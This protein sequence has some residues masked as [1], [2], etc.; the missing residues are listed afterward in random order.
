MQAAHSQG[1]RNNSGFDRLDD[2]DTDYASVY[3]ERSVDFGSDELDKDLS[4]SDTLQ[5]ISDLSNQIA[6]LRTSVEC[7]NHTRKNM[8]TGPLPGKNVQLAT[9]SVCSSCGKLGHSK[10]DRN[11]PA[12]GS[13]CHNCDKPGH[14]TSVCH[15]PQKNQSG[16]AP[17]R[18]NRTFKTKTNKT[19]RTLFVGPF[20]PGVGDGKKSVD[21][22]STPNSVPD[23][24]R[25]D[26]SVKEAGRSFDPIRLVKKDS[27]SA[28]SEI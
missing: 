25:Q 17:P 15:A 23:Q 5:E 28:T 26:C 9:H 2:S 14:W 24:F 12:R 22:E 8:Y 13:T 10:T 11:C 16:R 7:R 1:R 3:G 20:I 6:K 18:P 21:S 4:D 27:P 19:Q